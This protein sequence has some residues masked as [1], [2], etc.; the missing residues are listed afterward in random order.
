M[1]GAGFPFTSGAYEVSFNAVS[2]VGIS[3]YNNSG[4]LLHSTYLG[5]NGKDIPISLIVNSK[6]SLIILV[7]TGSDNL[8]TSTDAHDKN[9]RFGSSVYVLSANEDR[10]ADYPLG[11]DMYVSI[12]DSVLGDIESATYI[13]GNGNDGIN[14]EIDLNN[15][16]RHLNIN[17]GD[18]LRG[19]VIVDNMDNIYVVG[20]TNSTNLST[21]TNDQLK[22]Q[23]DGIIFKI[24]NDLSQ[25]L[26]SKYLGGSSLDAIYD[27]KI[28]QDTNIIV[29]GGTNS[30]DFPTTTGVIYE[31]IQSGINTNSNDYLADGFITIIDN[32]DGSMLRS[33]YLGTRSYDQV[34]FV[35]TDTEDDIL[36]YGQTAGDDYPITQNKYSN[37][38]SGQ[39]ITKID[40]SLSKALFSTVIGS[41]RG[42]PDISPTAFLVNECNNIYLAGWGSDIGTPGS[43]PNSTNNLPITENA[44]QKETDD[45]DFYLMVLSAEAEDL[46]YST[47]FGSTTA[48]FGGG[49]EHVDGG[50][51]RFNEKGEIYHSICACRDESTFP[52]TEGAWSR[53]NKST[54]CNNAAFKFGLAT[55]EVDFTTNSECLNVEV[56][57]L[58]NS[59]GTEEVIWDFGDGT[60]SN[61]QESTILHTYDNGG[62]YQVTLTGIN[63]SSCQVTKTSAKTIKV[64]DVN[65]T[66]IDTSICNGGSIQ[67]EIPK[68]EDYTYLWVPSVGISNTTINNPIIS[69]G[70]TTNYTLFIYAEQSCAFRKEINI[71]VS[72][73][74]I[75]RLDIS[76]V[77]DCDTLE[78]VQLSV[79]INAENY[80]IDLG[81]GETIVNSIPSDPIEYKKPGNYTINITAMNNSCSETIERNIVIDTSL[82][83]ISTKSVSFLPANNRI[84]ICQG[85]TISLFAEGGLYYR[86]Y[87]ESNISDISVANPNV[88]PTKTTTYYVEVT[89]ASNCSITDSFIVSIIEDSDLDFAITIERNCTDD[90]I[91]SFVLNKLPITP[92]II[93]EWDIGDGTGFI[94]VTPPSK[95]YQPGDY[96]V[97]MSIRLDSCKI[98]KTKEFSIENS[99]VYNAFTPNNDGYNEYFIIND[100]GWNLNIIDKWGNIVH[101]KENYNNEWDG[102]DL[103]GG[104][105]FFHIQ[106]DSIECK[107]PF[108]II[109]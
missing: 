25:V 27:L 17:Y 7:I 11:S 105:Y 8:P 109:R 13:G 94:G 19:S 50:T 1:F 108:Q 35:D 37:P 77:V 96:R 89:T 33:T 95:M 101:K 58:N 52:T 98:E 72:D 28:Y 71:N 23:Q 87:P 86:W 88:F 73:E 3:K 84:S 45:N 57:F 12:L 83:F 64:F 40:N 70:Q 78:K 16:Y 49:R 34:Y 100:L 15:S 82:S 21:I 69:P 6:N 5:G 46:L 102:G 74:L 93:I 63:K 26:W 42:I 61:E 62:E 30:P 39:F 60:I 10:T 47:F 80:I 48:L 54:N 68:T 41:G 53:I 66:N 90:P 92:G 20:S 38:N 24:N 55:L 91:V 97:T 75:E 85:D 43:L 76:K 56:E 51:S 36:V 32:R 9:F 4:T 99:L 14:D 18:E 29:V 81:N 65:T 107:G 103:P 2:D 67:L 106:K 79:D 44:Y 31:T 59:L 22:G 104:T